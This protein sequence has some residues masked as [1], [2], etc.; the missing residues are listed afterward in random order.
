VSIYAYI[1]TFHDWN[2][3]AWKLLRIENLERLFRKQSEICKML[4]SPRR[5]HILY[6]LRGGE[7]T[8]SDLSRLTGL[9]QANVSQHLALMRHGRIVVE[10]RVGNSVFYHVADERI[11]KACDLMQTVL[12]DQASEDSK[13]IRAARRR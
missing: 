12:L 1:R 9:R 2:I 6:E 7:K 5:L 11:T 4:S 8:V 13:L 3:G 10:R